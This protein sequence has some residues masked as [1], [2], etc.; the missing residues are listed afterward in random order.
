MI[1]KF[2]THVH[3]REKRGSRALRT[4]M[5]VLAAL[6]LILGILFNRGMFLPCFFMAALYFYFSANSTLD[7]EYTYEGRKL[8]IDVIKGKARRSTAHE[9]NLENLVVVAPHNAPEVA[10]YKKGAEEGNLP[11]FDYTS[12]DD[13]ISWYTMIIFEDK[14]KIKLLLDL[15]EDM[16]GQ[17]HREYPGKVII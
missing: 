15:E 6:F 13:D 10:G 3:R 11:K 8:T 7:Y 16:L 1:Y 14:R 5:I 17:M 2:V 12:Y 4:A 9:L